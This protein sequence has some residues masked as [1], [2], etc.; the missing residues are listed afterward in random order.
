M[1]IV[2]V[3]S[4]NEHGFDFNLKLFFELDELVPLFYRHALGYGHARNKVN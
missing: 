4:E 3:Q 1:A 2:Q